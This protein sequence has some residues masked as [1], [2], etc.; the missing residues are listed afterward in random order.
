[1]MSVNS[2]MV[3]EFRGISGEKGKFKLIYRKPGY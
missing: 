2:E 3:I 1:M